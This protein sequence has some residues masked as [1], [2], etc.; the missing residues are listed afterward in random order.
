MRTKAKV[1]IRLA[2]MLSAGS[3]LAAGCGSSSDSDAPPSKAV[4]VGADAG[5]LHAKLPANLR[6][7]KSIDVAAVSDYPPMSYADTDGSTIV[8]FNVDLLNAAAAVLGTKFNFKDTSF[9][10]LIPSL[11]AGRVALAE[12]GTTDTLVNEKAT[13]L[14]DYLNSGAQVIV[15]SGNPKK[16]GDFNTLCGHTVAT[17]AGSPTYAAA[18]QTGSTDCTKA[19]KPAID[20]KTFKTEDAAVLAL[21]AGRVDAAF[22]SSISNAYRLK[23]GQKIQVASQTYVKTPIGFQVLP[24]NKELA[25][26]LKEALQKLIDNGT[27]KTLL[28][29]WNL[30][31]NALT[32]MEINKTGSGA[33]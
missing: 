33:S 10:S 15:P 8:G 2:A 24:A 7:Q 29:K 22:D 23:K 6:S 31:A 16:L 9:D 28:A 27:Y 32:A 12:G 25:T 1:G 19:G 20:I 21:N 17:L 14:I 30:A 11:K 26:A 4:D 5:S 3:L 13:T 18:L